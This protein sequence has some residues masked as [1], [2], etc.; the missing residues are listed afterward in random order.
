MGDDSEWMKLPTEEKVEHKTWKA[1]V[2]GYEE[3]TKILNMTTEEKSPEFNK[4]AGLQ[5]KFVMDSN[6][7]AQE[8]ALDVVIV[9]AEKAGIAVLGR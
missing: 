8:K 2:A 1:R 7:I 4:Y 6:A 3:L 5:K 9:F